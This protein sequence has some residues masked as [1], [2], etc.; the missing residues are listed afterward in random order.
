M[1]KL[2]T[3]SG[4]TLPRI[5][6]TG[7]TFDRVDPEKLAAALGAEIV[8]KSAVKTQG[9]V[10]LFALRQY[11]LEN[12]QSS[13]GRPGLESHARRQKI[14]LTDEIWLALTGLASILR[15]DGISISPGQMASALIRQSLAQLNALPLH[16]V[17]R[18]K[19]A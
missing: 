12:L 3:N 2:I 13:G 6:Q 18:R 11:L 8:S 5:K 4:K 14:P 17:P 9:P 16:R 1:P 15:A 19:A 10:S 7:K